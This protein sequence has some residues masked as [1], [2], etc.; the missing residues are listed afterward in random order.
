MDGFFGDAA[1]AGQRWRQKVVPHHSK[2]RAQ[3]AILRSALFTAHASGLPALTE[4]KVPAGGECPGVYVSPPHES[5]QQATE[6]SVLTPHAAVML[7]LMDAKVP[8]GGVVSPR[9]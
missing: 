4:T 3:Q 9:L 1:M 6:P 8:V 5:P 2:G 7:T